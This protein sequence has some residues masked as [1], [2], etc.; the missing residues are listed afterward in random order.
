MT[1]KDSINRFLQTDKLVC[2]LDGKKLGPP[3]GYY[4]VKGYS[5]FPLLSWQWVKVFFGDNDVMR[6]C[7]KQE[8]LEFLRNGNLRQ[9]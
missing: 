6:F 4:K 1:L 5:Q 3:W 7:N 8:Y 2:N 9:A